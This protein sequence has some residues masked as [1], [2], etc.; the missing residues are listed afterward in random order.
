VPVVP[1][2][3]TRRRLRNGAKR[4][5]RITAD[6][7]VLPIGSVIRLVDAGPYTGTYRVEDTGRAV[8]GRELD[9]YIPNDAEAKRFGRK[10]LQVEIVDRAASR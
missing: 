3:Q 2:T 10:Q 9:M 6:P 5:V 7:A 8:H 4:N 1:R